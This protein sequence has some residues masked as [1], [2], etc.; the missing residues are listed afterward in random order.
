MLP[1]C[2]S[3]RGLPPPPRSSCSCSSL[4]STHEVQFSPLTPHFLCTS[5]RFCTVGILS[6]SLTVGA[7]LSKPFGKYLSVLVMWSCRGTLRLVTSAPRLHFIFGKASAVVTLV[8]Y[9]KCSEV[10]PPP[11]LLTLPSWSSSR[12]PVTAT[13]APPSSH[14]PSWHLTAP[15]SAVNLPSLYKNPLRLRPSSWPSL[16]PFWYTHRRPL[17]R[18]SST[19]F[20]ILPSGIALFPGTAPVRRSYF[21]FLA[22]ADTP[23]LSDVIFLC[24]GFIHSLCSPLWF[25]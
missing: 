8:G 24:Q 9:L 12:C 6:S 20:P 22:Q 13:P 21:H 10:L 14:L 15:F 1:P 19:C 23:H 2:L 17:N 5:L 3:L 16:M 7:K 25:S 11:I 4:T 18:V